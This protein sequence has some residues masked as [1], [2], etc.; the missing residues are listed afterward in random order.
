MYYQCKIS[1]K[2]NICY[3][4]TTES[5]K[6]WGC[7]LH[8]FTRTFEGEGFASIPVIIYRGGGQNCPS[9]PLHPLIP[10]VLLLILLESDCA[11]EFENRTASTTYWTVKFVLNL[12]LCI[13]AVHF[14]L[15]S[16]QLLFMF[17]IHVMPYLINKLL[18]AFCTT[19]PNSLY[20]SSVVSYLYSLI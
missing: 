9:N 18:L 19:Q 2:K 16:N 13:Q 10:T 17:S 1:R 8:R 3:A 7:T 14:F 11:I 6:I 5:L 20:I 4:G 12:A 15:I